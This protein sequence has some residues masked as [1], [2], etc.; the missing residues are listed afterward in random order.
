MSNNVKLTQVA[1]VAKKF[2]GDLE[3][4]KRELKRVASVKCRLKK[5]KAKPT[6]EQEMREVLAEYQLLKEVRDYLA[7]KKLTVTQMTA[8][9]IAK[10]T[11]D[12]TVKAIKSIQSKKCNT[13]YLTDRIEDNVE[14]Q[15]AVRIEEMLK[16]HREKIKPLENAVS[17]HSINEVVQHIENLEDKVDKEYVI[18]L[19]KKLQG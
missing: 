10:L 4:V 9:D 1:E 15:E 19:L 8:D 17:K 13:Q 3:A 16:A 14:Y 5:Q 18:E 2:N 7:P 6:Y 11:Y 12:E